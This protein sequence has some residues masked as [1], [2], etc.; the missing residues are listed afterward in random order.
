MSFVPSSY[1]TAIF[2]AVE[3]GDNSLLIEAVAGSGKTTT[4][5][6]ALNFL[7]KNLEILFMAFN[8]SI[9]N[10]LKVKVP[11]GINVATFH[12]VGF[13]SWTRHVGAR[14]RIAVKPSKS[15]NLC[16]E[17]MTRQEMGKYMAFVMKMV[18]LGKNSGIGTYLL[19]DTKEN[20][21]KLA[22]HFDVM[23]QSQDASYAEAYD[24]C[25][26][27]LR[28]S[29]KQSE[30]AIDYD[31]MLY[32]PLKERCAFPK[33][34]RVF[35]DEAQDTNGPQRELLHRM[36]MP[37]AKLV[38]VGD[39]AQAIYGFRGA[40]SNAMSAIESEF[41]CKRLPLR[42]SYRCAKS[43]IKA[44]QVYMPEIEAFENAPEGIVDTFPTYG[45]STFS[46][47]DVILCRNTAPLISIAYGLIGRGIGI[48][49]LGRE[50]GKGLKNLIK[51]MRASDVDDLSLKLDSWRIRESAKL[52]EKDQEAKIDAVEDKVACI[53]VIIN[54]LSEDAR[55]I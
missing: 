23:L 41:E 11:E 12:S 18:G 13:R 8:K 54:N 24:L 3:K 51:R 53:N 45:A 1:Q 29:C 5:L 49:F 21:D 30:Y 2:E 43:I 9:V 42:K 33:Y 48:N 38:G 55:S 25:S 19:E 50:I 46:N 31:D 47:E 32:M 34:D 28:M 14:G 20:W 27:V 16:K 52:R 6:E 39:T 44:V 4:I 36:L 17:L 22:L 10:E 26:R 40:D 37:G 7:P 35:I 15:Y